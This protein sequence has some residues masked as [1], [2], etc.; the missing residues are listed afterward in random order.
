MNN[1][2]YINL[3]LLGAGWELKTIGRKYGGENLYK[4]EIAQP[5]G[6]GPITANGYGDTLAQAFENACKK[7]VELVEERRVMESV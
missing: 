4:C 3:D 7:A 5:P 2:N 6:N 1:P